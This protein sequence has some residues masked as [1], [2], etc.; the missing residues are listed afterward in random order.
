MTEAELLDSV[1]QIITSK[2][3]G[4]VW[5]TALDLKYAFSQSPL[6]DSV[7]KHCNFSIVC[8]K[9]TGTY[10]FKAGFYGLTGVFCFLDDILI[11]S[12]SSILDHNKT[13]ENVLERLDDEG[14]AL[15]GSKCKVSKKSLTCLGFNID[16][17]GKRPKHSKIESVLSLTPPKTLKQLSSFMGFSNHF[18]RFI[19]NLQSKTEPLRPSLTANNKQSFIW[20]DVQ[21]IAFK[22]MLKAIGDITKMF[23]YDASKKSRIKSDASHKGLGAALEQE[24]EPGIWAPNAFT[25]R[26]LNQTEQKYSTYELELLAVVWSCE[27]FK[28]YLLGNHFF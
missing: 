5:F 10:R 20:T 22:E 8:G 23:H 15:K 11:V 6:D 25:S 4:K 9:F 1:A 17:E 13:V 2:D 16:S 12:K 24:V 27:Y 3:P 28:N 26:F 21:E 14:F 18:S 7:S 19:P